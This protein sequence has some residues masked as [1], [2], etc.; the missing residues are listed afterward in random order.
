[1]RFEIEP[2]QMNDEGKLGPLRDICVVA[3]QKVFL[4]RYETDTNPTIV[5]MILRGELVDHWYYR[6]EEFIDQPYF[7][8]A[9]FLQPYRGP[10]NVANPGLYG[11]ETYVVDG[12]LMDLTKKGFVVE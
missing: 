9:H 12:I 4:A 1:M 10:A 7:L 3:A 5:Q 8:P 6:S 11:P 2:Q